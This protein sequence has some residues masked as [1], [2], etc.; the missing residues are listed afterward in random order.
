MAWGN[1]KQTSFAD[2][3]VCTH[4]ALEE[5]D[6]VHNLIH[7]SRLENLLR[8]IHIKRRGENS[9]IDAGM[10]INIMIDCSHGNSNK[11]PAN[12]PVVFNNCIDQIVA[13]NDNIIGMM[14]ESNLEWGKQPLGKDTSQL[15]RGVSITDACIDWQTTERELLNAHK[16]LLP[17]IERRKKKAV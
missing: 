5:L 15:K 4:S 11:D 8:Q 17:V 14:V 3:L 2:A 13:S 6:D 10:P 7:W 12:Q 9:L 16:R 1:L